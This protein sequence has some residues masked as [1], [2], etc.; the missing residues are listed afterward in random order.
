MWSGRFRITAASCTP[1]LCNSKRF[2]DALYN[3]LHTELSTELH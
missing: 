1:T 2:V 3:E